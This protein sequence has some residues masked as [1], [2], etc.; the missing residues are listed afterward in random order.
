MIFQLT[1]KSTPSLLKKIVYKRFSHLAIL[2][3]LQDIQFPNYKSMVLL[4]PINIKNTS[5]LFYIFILYIFLYI[6]FN[7]QHV[8]IL[9]DLIS[10]T[11]G[12]LIIYK[13]EGKEVS[14]F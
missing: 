4:M 11:A 2:L 8:H 7:I 12:C 9:M 1:P 13:Q 10:F 6:F 5:I 14:Q 3:H